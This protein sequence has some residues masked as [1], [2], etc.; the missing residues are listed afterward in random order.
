[1]IQYVPGSKTRNEEAIDELIASTSWTV[2]PAIRIKK[3]ADTIAGAMALLH[4]GEWRVQID[5]DR[6][7]VFVVQC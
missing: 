5:H 4:G 1:M 3:A 6:G 7:F 2:D